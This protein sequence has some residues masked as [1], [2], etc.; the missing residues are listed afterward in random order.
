MN[1]I[2]IALM[3]GT[4]ADMMP[5]YGIEENIAYILMG[6]S[7][8]NN[9]KKYSKLD[10]QF[11]RL[12]KQYKKSNRSIYY[13][14]IAFT[15]APLLNAAGRLGYCGKAAAC[16]YL[17][18]RLDIEKGI[19]FL[20]KCNEYRKSMT[21]KVAEIAIKDIEKQMN[22]NENLLVAA[23]DATQYPKGLH[24]LIANKLL[25]HFSTPAIVYSN[26]D[27]ILSGSCRSLAIFDIRNNMLEFAYNTQ[28]EIGVAGHSQACAL[29]IKQNDLQSLLV[30]LSAK[31]REA[32]ESVTVGE[33]IANEY[34]CTISSFTYLSHVL[35]LL[36]TLVPNSKDIN[37]VFRS[38]CKI[39]DFSAT[40]KNIANYWVTFSAED[41]SHIK[42]WF[43][44]FIDYITTYNLKKDSI[45]D[46]YY[47]V[48]Q[49]FLEKDGESPTLKI[50]DMNMANQ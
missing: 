11:L 4:I 16:F 35:F 32:L 27:G 23:F 21:N 48:E 50:L 26:Y 12:L 49:S 25:E 41:G 24:G 2:I 43:K 9:N 29:N 3:L 45:V 8:L 42:I 13:S 33:E 19:L 30:Y 28:K 15:I 34:V 37:T 40:K 6:L 31:Y 5:I 17:K 44:N 14:D 36:R 7:T 20:D 39:T 38:K 10:N 22:N 18:E 47:N 46:I 1:G